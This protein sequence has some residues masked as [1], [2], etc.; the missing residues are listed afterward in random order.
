MIE[1]NIAEIKCRIAIAS[2]GRPVHLVAAT[3]SVPAGAV[4]EAVRAGVDAVGENRVQELLEKDASGAYKG[5][6]L[7]FIGHLQKNKIS[8][9][10]GRADLI[11]SIGSLELAGAVSDCAER[12]GICQ[13]VLVQVNIGLEAAKGGV[14][15]GELAEVLEKMS[16][17]RG[18]DVLGLMCI[19][20]PGEPRCFEEMRRLFEETQQITGMGHLSMGMSGDY[21]EAVRAGASMVRVGSLIFGGRG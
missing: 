18:I 19:P 1:K 17:L 5:V 20:P 10:V 6:P 13:S 9:I 11:H 4:R 3:K 12:L 7:H 2:G 21:E 8:K 14:H 16:H 15:P